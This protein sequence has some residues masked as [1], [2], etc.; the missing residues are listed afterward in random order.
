MRSRSLICISCLCL[1]A[2]AGAQTVP[3]SLAQDLHDYVATPAVS[4]YEQALADHIAQELAGFNPT[5]DN[6]DDVIVTLAAPAGA[7][8]PPLLLAAP[9]DEPGYVVSAI[10]PQGYLRVQR[11][12]TRG[13]LPLFNVLA[14]A[15][16]VQVETSAGAWLPGVV[17]GISV[18]L[19]GGRSHPPD[20]ADLNNVYIDIGA[21]TA[22]EVRAAGIHVLSPIALDRSLQVLGDGQLSGYS[23]GDR[24][25]AAALVEA[26]RHLDAAHLPGAV[27]VA[28]VNQQWENGRGLAR[29]RQMVAQTSGTSGK[30]APAP[31]I[32][33]GWPAPAVMAARLGRRTANPAASSA[34]Q[35]WSVP[36]EWR[37]TP[38]A[39]IE[40][41]ALA[42]LIA[43][44]ETALGETPAPAALPQPALLPTPAL[45][46]RPSSA[47]SATAIVQQ[48]VTQY[49]VHPQEAPVAQAI[50]NLLPAWAQPT[51][52]SA[53][54][55]VLHWADAGSRAPRLLFVAHQDE[56]GFAVQSIGRDG[57]LQLVTRGG[58]DLSFY[59]GH[60]ILVHTAQGMRPGVLEL[61]EGWDQAGFETINRRGT[62]RAN[63]ARTGPPELWADV[64]A[65]SPEDAAHLG[66][67]VGDTVTIPK[68]YRALLGDRASARSFDDRVGDAALVAAAWA[69]G[70]SVPGRDI[71]FVWSTGEEEGLL[72]AK[73]SAQRLDAAGREPDYVFAVDTF[74]SSD[75]PVESHR[76]ADA[77]LGQ[78]FVIR[79]IDDSSITP[80]ALARRVRSMALDAHI[81]VQVG[82]TSGGNDGSAFVP[83]GAVDIPLGWPLRTSHSPAEVIDTRDMDGL[84]NIITTLAQSW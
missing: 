3:G 80:W 7:T 74:V 41:G 25:G 67:A 57:R 52:D 48:L 29:V 20:P 84:A 58:V 43:R 9:L 72:G 37:S 55:L 69:L 61:P 34:V 46:A 22:A 83:F 14:S 19:L 21:S 40:G 26:L 2:W 75:S 42:Q 36:V 35:Y 63:G 6:L 1:A 51:L 60:P 28:F 81:P 4:G 17:T 71:T 27:T 59:V 39:T 32:L 47:P 31:A 68:R 66:I 49:G 24:Y 23:I 73:V 30:G 62:A 44:V 13:R 16:P 45:P 56:T 50:E 11:L 82:E 12:P 18:H 65:H 70:P 64:G 8:A 79:A 15:Q 5:R 77:L 54:N 10:T 33:V 53:G 76:Y 78:G 38:A